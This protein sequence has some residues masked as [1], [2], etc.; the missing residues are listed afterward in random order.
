MAFTVL[1]QFCQGKG[2][3]A[4]CEDRLII[5]P[6][7]IAVI[8]GATSS[9]PLASGKAGG[10]VAA[11]AIAD[12]IQSLNPDATAHECITKASQAVFTATGVWPDASQNRPCAA[13]VVYS[14]ARREIWR[15]CDCHIRIDGTAYDGEV[16]VGQIPYTFRSA[17]LRARLALGQT[18]VTAEQSR[19][20]EESLIRPFVQVQNVFL[21]NPTDPMG[22]GAIN[23]L[24][25]PEK[26]IEVFKVPDAKE[27]ILCSDGFFTP[28]ATLAEGLAELKRLKH[29]D[30][31]LCHQVNGSRP[32]P[33]D[34][35]FFDDTT[36]VRFHQHTA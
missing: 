12:T 14:A 5:T 3:P 21:N 17:I 10:I 16:L 33:A 29:E 11:E 23:G 34:G 22:F 15:V 32:F 2:D 26:F 8:D 4:A 7:F 28:P 6:H 9:A 18:T 19:P 25:V 36:Y 1:E 35:D 20:R 27:I 31:L 13:I 24:P 30:P